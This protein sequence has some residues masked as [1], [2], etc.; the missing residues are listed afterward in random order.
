M[1][2]DQKYV[3]LIRAFHGATNAKIIKVEPQEKGIVL[4]VKYPD[5]YVKGGWSYSSIWIPIR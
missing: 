2:K 5:S 4:Y 1:K 3:E